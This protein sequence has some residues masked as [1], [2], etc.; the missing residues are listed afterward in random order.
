MPFSDDSCQQKFP[1]MKLV[2]LTVGLF[3]IAAHSIM[4]ECKNKTDALMYSIFT[5]GLAVCV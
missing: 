1:C 3:Q 2:V 5:K 4:R